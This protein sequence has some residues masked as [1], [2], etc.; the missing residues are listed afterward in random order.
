MT[1][2]ICEPETRTDVSVV[3]VVTGVLV[4]L[5]L[6]V[7]ECCDGV[8]VYSDCEVVEPQSFSFSKK[9]PVVL[10]ENREEM[11]N[12]NGKSDH[13]VASR[14][15]WL[16][17]R[18]QG[19]AQQERLQSSVEKGSATKATFAGLRHVKGLQEEY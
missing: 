1:C 9:R 3:P 16:K 14:N 7:T 18:G 13:L 10:E 15:R 11:R 6:V 2:L 5:S 8:S 19:V 4:S 17:Y 12:S